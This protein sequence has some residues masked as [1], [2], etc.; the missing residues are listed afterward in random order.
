[1]RFRPI[2]N[3]WYT[4]IVSQVELLATAVAERQEIEDPYIIG[5]PLTAHQ[6]IFVGREAFSQRIEQLLLDR[7]PPPLLIY[8]QRRMGK[9]SLLNNLGRL[10]PQHILPLFVDLQGP[11]A[12]ASDHAVCSTIWRGGC[13]VQ[14]MTSARCCCRIYPCQYPGGSV[15]RL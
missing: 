9:T 11:V 8:G 7:R 15:Y 5:I 10:L 1:L 3:Q 2:A 14:P 6:E 12:S 13:G 4:M